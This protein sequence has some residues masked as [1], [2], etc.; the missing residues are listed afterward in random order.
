MIFC[1]VSYRQKHFTVCQTNNPK[2][3]WFKVLSMVGLQQCMPTHNDSVFQEWCRH[4]LSL[5]LSQQR[6]GFNSLVLVAWWL[7]KHRNACVF[8]GAAPSVLKIFQDIEEASLWCMAGAKALSNL[9][10]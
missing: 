7:W 10:P 4:F 3:T 8:E 6:K 5:I 2:E 1:L 9:W